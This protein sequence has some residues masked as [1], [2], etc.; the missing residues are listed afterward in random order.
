M[1]ALPPCVRRPTPSRPFSPTPMYSRSLHHPALTALLLAAFAS[2]AQAADF[3]KANNETNLDALAAWVNADNTPITVAPANTT[4]STDTWIFDNRVILAGDLDGI[5]SVTVGASKDLGVR[6]IQIKDPALPVSFNGNGRTF[7]ATNNGGI[8]MASATKDLTLQNMF[9]RVAASGNT[10][11]L[12][13]ATGRTLTFGSTAQV[14]VRSNAGSVTV[15]CN[16][17]GLSTGTIIFGAA[18]APSNV[19]IGAGRVEFNNPAGNTRLGT[20]T[21]TVNGGTLVV[22]NTTGSA[23]G[24]SP[25]TLNNTAILTG[26]GI[27]TGLVT[28]NAGTTLAPGLNGL[29]TLKVGSLTLATD[30]KIAWEANNPLEADTLQ[31]TGANG[32]TINGGVVSLYNP[33][34]TDPLTAVG[35]FDLIKFTGTLNGALSNLTLNPATQIAGRIYTLGLGANGVTLTIA[36]DAAVERSWDADASGTW[37]TAVNWTGDTVPNAIGTIANITGAAGATFSAP[38]TIT[39]DAA[40]TVGALTLASAQSVTLAGA[41]TLTLDNKSAAALLNASGADHLI[42]TPLALTAGGVLADIAETKTLTLG[43][44]VS[45]AGVG[46]VKSGAGSLLL[47]ADNTYSGTTSISGGTLQIGNGGTTGSV[48]G[49]ITN[50]GVVR[51]NRTDSVALANVLSGT[52]EFQFVGTGDTTLSAANT[53]SGNTTLSAGTLI[54]ANSAAL[55]NSTLT[56]STTG[57]TLVV[58]DPVAALTLGGLAGDRALPLVNTL[59]APLALNVGQNNAS[60]TYTG[61]PSGTGLSFTKSGSGTLTLGGTHTYSGNTTVSA[62]TLAVG[63]G[64]T[65]NT[66]AANLGTASTAKLLVNGG[67]LNASGASL[68][69]NASIGFEVTSGI[70]NF[71]GG[72][73]T[74]ANQ[75]SAEPFINVT[76]GTLNAASISLSRGALNI[77]SEPASGQVTQG[78]YVNGGAVN[79]TGALGIGA[80]TGANSSVSARVDSGSLTVDGVVTVGINNTTRWSVLDINGGTFTSTDTTS[81][82][83]LGSPFAGQVI[84]HVRGSAVAKAQRI[85]FGQGA[86][87]GK[88]YLNLGGGTLYVGSGGLVL[89]SSE[90]TFVAGLRLGGGTLG[91]LADWSSTLPVAMNGSP[92]IVTGADDLN[93]PRVITLQGAATGLGALTKN[94]AGTVRFTSPS[95]DYFGPTLVNAGRLGLAGHTSDVITVAAGATLAPEGTLTAD[96]GASI[97]G[98]LAIAYAGSASPQV[99]SI[100]AA[101]GGFT[102]GAASTLNLSGTGSLNAPFYVLLKGTTAVTGTFATVSGLPAGYSLSYAYDDDANEATPAVVALVAAPL[103]PYQTWAAGFPSL[104]DTLPASDP[105]SDG[106]S[107]FAEYALAQSPVVSDAASAYTTGRSGNF[108]TLAFD[109]PAD[110]SLRYEIEAKSDLA[111][112]T[113][114]VVYTFDPFT[115]AGAASYTDTADLTITPRRFLRLKVT[116][117]P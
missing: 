36:T 72:I 52:G 66:A 3:Y 42:S 57:G 83:L 61:S 55:Q 105:D 93:A 91:A 86:L 54:I 10:I 70:A 68:L 39:L 46:L 27:V 60:T 117:T 87:A 64:A 107:N 33:G 116:Q 109:H 22:G 79:V 19:I 48:A 47:T 31:V 85:Q 53:Y 98:T 113:W 17:D 94:G 97:E 59:S 114:T 81:G 1:A 6:T 14:S 88:S 13:V 37:S 18:F 11:N 89:G 45:G 76:G 74:E 25:I 84:M 69:T 21:T 41:A 51:L 49:T 56:Y 100:T 40:R 82:V 58:A 92:S 20:P 35:V 115:T 80:L 99:P 15:N 24:S 44:A 77:G 43:G 30:S 26:T 78:L 34:T 16:T 67:A 50:S 111:A 63:T 95:N 28:A 75:S 96:T 110:A 102:L 73:V 23:T 106:L 103:S 62:G 108:L 104:T 112:A 71:T 4:T 38:R 32:L 12:Q 2:S 7:T 29:G 5:Q 8:D 9:Y 101:S 65:F 90:P